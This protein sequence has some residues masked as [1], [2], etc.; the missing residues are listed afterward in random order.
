MQIVATPIAFAI[1][2]AGCAS[3]P[4]GSASPF[5]KAETKTESGLA[6]RPRAPATK[7]PANERDLAATK[8]AEAQASLTRVDS[9]LVCMVTNHFKG[10]P[11][12]PVPVEDKTYFAC[13]PGCKRR[14]T[15]DPVSRAAIDPLSGV[16]VDKAVAVIAKSEAGRIVYFESEENLARYASQ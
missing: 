6:L 8:A 15:K 11:Q 2:L 14:L 10:V 1:V 4:V 5:S 9:S 13:C 16:A 3:A 12:I 7:P